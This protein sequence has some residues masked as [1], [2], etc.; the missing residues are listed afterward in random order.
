MFLG[1]IYRTSGEFFKYIGIHF[2]V[3]YSKQGDSLHFVS[4]STVKVQLGGKET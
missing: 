4:L 1:F 2:E 3:G